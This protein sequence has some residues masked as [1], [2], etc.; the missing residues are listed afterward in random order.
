MAWLDAILG[1]KA[2]LPRVRE[3]ETLEIPAIQAVQKHARQGQWQKVRDALAAEKDSFLRTKYFD[4]C[5]GTEGVEKW[6]DVWLA[7]EPDNGDA[8]ILAGKMSIARGS[9]IRG[10]AKAEDTPDEAWDP[11]HEL[12]RKA[13]D[14]LVRAIELRPDDPLPWVELIT[15]SMV[16]GESIEERVSRFEHALLRDDSLHTPH[17]VIMYALTEKWGGSHDLMF[18]I[19]RRSTE[20]A[21]PGTAIPAVIAYAHI[22][23][24]VYIRH[25]E[26]DEAR[27]HSYFA[28][29]AVL[30]E[31][32]AAH[33][34]C[35]ELDHEALRIWVANVFAFCFYYAGEAALAREEFRKAG[36]V[37]SGL[38]WRYVGRGSYESALKEVW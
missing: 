18:E 26:K 23:R 6:L 12:M 30:D 8:W 31:I 5:S 25:W 2:N 14:E 32:R 35:G 9:E 22:E 11:F 19:A 24:W 28:E 36:G 20:T 29:P 15:T 7:R 27:K 16:L 37:F 3:D 10:A 1:R 38:P 34:L 33:A 21:P 13:E 17:T 4:V